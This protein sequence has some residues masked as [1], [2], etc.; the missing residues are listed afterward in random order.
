MNSTRVFKFIVQKDI[1]HDE[2]RQIM[3][4][5]TDAFRAQGYARAGEHFCPDESVEGGWEFQGA[6]PDVPY[7]AIRHDLFRPELNCRGTAVPGSCAERLRVR[8]TNPYAIPWGTHGEATLY[9]YRGKRD[10]C[11]ERLLL[12]NDVL[13]R[14]GFL[15]FAL[16][17]RGN[18]TV[19]Q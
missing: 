11:Y 4:D 18:R 17:P 13:T 19:F 7:L 3:V 5:L 9:W 8:T 2:Y 12:I 1:T 6:T 14:H 16:A 15:V 10:L